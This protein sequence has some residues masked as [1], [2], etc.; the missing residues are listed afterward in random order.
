MPRLVHELDAAAVGHGL[1]A[2]HYPH[3]A[4]GVL[5]VEQWSL[6]ASTSKLNVFSPWSP[7]GPVPI[8]SVIVCPLVGLLHQHVIYPQPRRTI[9]RRPHQGRILAL[10]RPGNRCVFT[11]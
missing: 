1:A 7:N 2:Q 10:P 9:L 4:R 11:E 8:V 6:G 5:E 3:P